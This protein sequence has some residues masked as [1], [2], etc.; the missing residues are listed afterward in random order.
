LHDTSEYPTTTT[1]GDLC[2]PYDKP[3]NALQEAPAMGMPSQHSLACRVLIDIDTLLANA[4]S[5]QW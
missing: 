1:T 4:L 2:L 3:I 5:G